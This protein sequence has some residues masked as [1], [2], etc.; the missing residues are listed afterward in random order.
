MNENRP[1]PFSNMTNS[2]A[3]EDED[4]EG[5]LRNRKVRP[6]CVLILIDMTELQTIC[7]RL[8]FI[9]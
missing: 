1:C 6:V 9:G 7:N 8:L 4:G 5:R 3:D 2:F